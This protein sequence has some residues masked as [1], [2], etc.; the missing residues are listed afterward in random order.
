MFEHRWNSKQVNEV[1]HGNCAQ[2]WT[3][4]LYTTA[5]EWDSGVTINDY[6]KCQFCA[7]QKV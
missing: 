7:Q 2:Q 4:G 3:L 1:T 5:Q 6:E